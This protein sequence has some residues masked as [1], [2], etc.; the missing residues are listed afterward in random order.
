MDHANHLHI[1]QILKSALRKEPVEFAYLFGSLATGTATQQSDADIAVF[2]SDTLSKE[3]RFS[4]RLKLIGAISRI[5]KRRVDVVV[6]NDLTS[7]F[8]KYIIIQEGVMIYEKS[9]GRRADFENRIL[10]LYFDFRPFLE[11]Y[12]RR[13]VQRNVQ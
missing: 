13:Y 2:I 10:S 8:F 3:E 12:N 5:L 4:L 9:G 7:L 11:A 6:L 1:V